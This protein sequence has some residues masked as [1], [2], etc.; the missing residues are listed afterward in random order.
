MCNVGFELFTEDGTSNYYIPESE[1]GLRDGDT[2]RLNK[3]CVRKMCPAIEAPL[4]GR[5]LTD[6]DTYRFGDMIKFMCDFGYVMEGSSSLLCTSA[7]EWNGTAPICNRKYFQPSHFFYE[8]YTTFTIIEVSSKVMH[9][10]RQMQSKTDESRLIFRIWFFCD[11]IVVYFSI[12]QFF[13]SF[14]K[15]HHFFR[16]HATIP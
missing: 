8:M 16:K 6:M 12:F 5:V 2:Y 10:A 7:A 9:T 14:G 1:T 11:V 15:R 13:F 4:N 3:T